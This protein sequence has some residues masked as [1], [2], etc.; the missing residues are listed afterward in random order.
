MGNGTV[1]SQTIGTIRVLVLHNPPVNAMS[2][3]L[4]R[5]L[6]E[7]L[8]AADTDTSIQGVILAAGG[9]GGF[10]GADIRFQGGNWPENEPRL[11]ALIRALDEARKPI[12]ALVRANA[13]GGGLEIAMACRFRA[14]TT[15]TKLGQPEVNLGIPPGAGGTQ[16]LPRLVGVENALD[17]I[18]TGRPITAEQAKEVGLID[19]LLPEKGAAVE[20]AAVWLELRMAEGDLPPPVSHREVPPFADIVFDDARAKA[21]KRRRGQKSPAI[22]IDC[23]EA[24]TQM[25][26]EDGIAFERDQFS[27]AV[28]SKEAA[29]LRHVFVAE[30]AARKIHG[31]DTDQTASVSHVG[32]VGAGTMGSG[33][34]LACLDA[35]LTVTVADQN[36]EMLGRAQTK[37]RQTYE[38]QVQKGRVSEEDAKARQSRIGFG[39]G[40]GALKDC[41][42]VIEAAFE[43]LDVKRSI[44]AELA[45]VTRVGTILA[46]NTSYLDVDRI[47][48]ATGVRRADVVGLHFF[49]PANIMP[50]LEIVRAEATG[51]RALSTSVEMGKRLSKTAIVSRVCPGF[52]ANRTFE[53][54][55]REAE[56]LLQEGASPTQVDKAL[57]EFGMPMGPFAVRDLAGLDIGWARRKSVAHERDPEK[58]YSRVGDEICEK[59]WFGQKT[60]KGFY[61][62]E[63]GN[64]KPKTNP[65]VE[66]IIRRTAEEDGVKQ[67][68][69]SDQEIVERCF[70]QVVNEAAQ[71]LDEG[72]ASRA[73][74]VDLVWIAGYGFPRWRGGPLFW[75]SGLGFDMVLSRVRAFS[76]QHDY[77]MPS[78][79]LVSLAEKGGS[80][81]DVASAG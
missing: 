6:I 63:P 14:A 43:D 74:D 10:A 1:L 58:R 2:P 71:L 78:P 64:R 35:G 24:A 33:I 37:V 15:G 32:V 62:Y 56:F 7:A 27:K 50:L 69:I 53:K 59:G 20:Q 76:E 22:C 52:I 19:L 41:D 77:W 60:G 9:K 4:P 66:E 25:D 46:T 72:I 28:T 73:S 49:S 48:E 67:R 42:L 61:L 45:D 13:L 38:G 11:P 81:A 5:E 79:V 34:A 18:V 68:E 36:D 70:L 3:G 23:V 21:R 30:R 26:F 57:T 16:R 75:A 31:L 29:A 80:L 55:T 54:Y 51:D 47:A 44:F 40:L 8:D 17:M 39:V 12:V 65:D